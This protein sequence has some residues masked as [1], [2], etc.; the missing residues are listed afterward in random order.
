M[1]GNGCDIARPIW[2]YLVEAATSVRPPFDIKSDTEHLAQALHRF[3]VAASIHQPNVVQLPLD[4]R[5]FVQT[6][7]RHQ[8]P[9]RFALLDGQWKP[10][11]AVGEGARGPLEQLLPGSL[12]LR[13]FDQLLGHAGEVV[14]EQILDRFA[15][16]LQKLCDR[17]PVTGEVS[18]ERLAY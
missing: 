1:K 18:D 6:F 11:L 8:R 5:P 17:S 9:I 10:A 7:E 15:V 2:G 16:R 12:E 14:G 4:R 13:Q 3:S